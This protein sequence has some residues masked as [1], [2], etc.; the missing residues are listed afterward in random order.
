MNKINLNEKLSLFNDYWNP[1]IISDLNDNHVK[2]VDDL[3]KKKD[4]DLLGK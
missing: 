2:L 3:Q 1:R 4:A